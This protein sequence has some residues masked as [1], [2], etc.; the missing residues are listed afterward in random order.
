MLSTKSRRQ[1]RPADQNIEIA[2]PMVLLNGSGREL[3][4]AGYLEALIPLQKSIDALG[5][6]A[7]HG[8]D[9]PDQDVYRQACAEHRARL[10]ALKTIISDLGELAQRGA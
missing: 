3:L 5:Q 10:Q 6:I 4:L 7:P 1:T 9:Y 8:R 2:G